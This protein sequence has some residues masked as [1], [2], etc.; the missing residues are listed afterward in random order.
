M[1]HKW[2]H[3]PRYGVE[4]SYPIGMKWLDDCKVVEDWGCALCH[5]KTYRK[6]DYVGIDGTPGKADVIADLSTYKSN[7]EGVFMRH[8]LEHNPDWR[9]ILANALGSFTKRMTLITFRPLTDADVT[10]TGKFPGHVD[11]DMCG[12]DFVSAIKPYLVDLRTVWREK[13]M[14]DVVYMLEK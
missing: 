5:A 6:G 13:G 14:V 12:R 11:I 3:K 9:A 10:Y 2:P 8:I 7:V 1:I 4:D